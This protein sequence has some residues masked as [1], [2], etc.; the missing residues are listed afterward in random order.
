MTDNASIFY[1]IGN[2]LYV[3]ITNRCPCDCVFCIRGISDSVGDAATLWLDCDPAIDEIKAAFPDDLTDITEIVFC[4]YG[5]PM[6]RADDVIEICEFIKSKTQL[7]L[8]LN[9][10][11]LV[12]LSNPEFDLSRVCVFD[13]V[14]VSL[15]ADNAADYQKLTR[16]DFGEV[17][18]DSMLSFAKEIKAYTNVCFSVVDVE[19]VNIEKCKIVSEKAGISLRIRNYDTNF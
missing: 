4:G 8:R 19:G 5:E 12:K 2:K 13:C 3:N 18:F 1:R 9:T 11:G 15:N 7:P 6:E 14:S 17:S 10:N 16:S